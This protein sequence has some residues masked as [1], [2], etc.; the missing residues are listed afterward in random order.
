LSI[1]K[2]SQSSKEGRGHRSQLFL[3]K[4]SIV[5][6]AATETL[7][8]GTEHQTETGTSLKQTQTGLLFLVPRKLLTDADIRCPWACVGT[9]QES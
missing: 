9:K 2:D 8:G 7:W 1:Q 4:V 6:P 3:K 5:N